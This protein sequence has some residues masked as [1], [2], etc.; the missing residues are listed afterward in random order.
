MRGG[1]FPRLWAS[2]RRIISSAGYPLYSGAP[3]TNPGSPIGL[4]PTPE[5]ANNT[6]LQPPAPCSCSASA[7]T[8]QVPQRFRSFDLPHTQPLSSKFNTYD[9]PGFQKRSFRGCIVLVERTA[10]ELSNWNVARAR[11]SSWTP[12]SP[13]MS[14]HS[15]GNQY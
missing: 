15:T 13:S 10:A 7:P 1:D 5:E 12:A 3:D 11:F 14:S 4:A 6:D 8:W 2:N 9:S